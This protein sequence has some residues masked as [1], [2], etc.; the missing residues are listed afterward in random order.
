[1]KRIGIITIQKCNN[2]GA[3]L[4]AFAL[5][6]KLQLMGY[7]VENIDF[8]FYK[9]PD[10]IKT[11]KSQPIFDL[12]TVNQLKEWLLPKITRFRDIKRH[13]LIKQRQQAFETFFEK[14]VRLSR[15]YSSLDALYVD[16]PKYDVYV[17]GSDQVWNPRIACNIKPYFL[18]FAP[19]ESRC[20]SYASSIGMP[21][22]SPSV[23]E[24]YKKLLSRYSA[25]GVRETTAERI[26]SGMGLGVP[27][28][29]VLD[30]TLLLSAS[31]WMAVSH[32]PEGVLPRHYVVE[33]N[34]GGNKY[35]DDFARR[36]AKHF[37]L[38]L[39]DVTLSPYGPAEF[40]W[41]M[42]NARAAVV[43]SF[44]GT[45]FSAM[46]GVPFYSVY[47][48]SA[49][50]NGGRIVLFANSIG[51]GG[52][53]VNSSMLES[54]KLDFDVDF[55]SVDACLA[56]MREESSMF[57]K[58]AVDGGLP[59]VR[60]SKVPECYA[61]WSLND[62]IRREST[63]GGAFYVFAEE[64]IKKGGVVFGAAF[65]SDFHHVRHRAARSIVELFALMKSKYVQSDISGILE[66][67]WNEVKSGK[68]VLF[69]GTPC[70]I[71]AVKNRCR[72]YL[73]NLL[74]VDIVCHGTPRP[75]V[76]AAYLKELENEFKD[77]VVGYEFRNKKY[78]WNFST[79]LISLKS[80]R[81][82]CRL[83]AQD[84]YFSGFSRNVFLR[85]SCYSCPYARLERISDLTIADC[86]RVA[87]SH[88]QYDDGKGTSLLLVNTK[89]GQLMF[90]TIKNAKSCCWGE[91]DVELARLRNTPLMVP[92][93][94]S[95]CCLKFNEAFTK[96]GSFD[97]AAKVYFTK[98]M[99]IKGVI[100][101]WI[102]KMGWFYL[103]RHQ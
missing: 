80:G 55:R 35:V 30:P 103:K 43:S 99:Q 31:E 33:Y 65:D 23:Y 84:S 41:L 57:L 102:K 46:N 60:P 72:D 91:Y 90:D 62:K 87:T 39:I 101:W 32:Q 92:A 73:S 51:L 86:W 13:G 97:M 17:T 96:T 76:F 64:V 36:C 29:T 89:K 3:D 82:I 66:E 20:I 16:P 58:D 79:I 40:I 5:Q 48:E 81:K 21:T 83:A 26:I 52:R 77:K 71:S 38:P 69:S 100:R 1:M 7:E 63:S 18:D 74:T 54:V 53:M 44:H 50:S 11:P 75:E 2:Y 59:D 61:L 94:R 98:S 24:A 28:K 4:Q 95:D 15:T 12:S 8:L 19:P 34:L 56:R 67:V 27:V 9:H 78:G 45:V 37:S 42:A 14:N 47:S 93:V 10:F 22:I 85:N 88:P 49:V 6:R 70:Q 25:I 68:L